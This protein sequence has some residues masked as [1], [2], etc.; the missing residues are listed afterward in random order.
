[1]V[2]LLILCSFVLI[3]VVFGAPT[4]HLQN[5]FYESAT[6]PSTPDK[7]AVA[8]DNRGSFNQIHRIP[9]K[10]HIVEP[11]WITVTMPPS[12]PGQ[13]GHSGQP[14]IMQPYYTYIPVPP[15]NQPWSGP[16]PTYHPPMPVLPPLPSNQLCNQPSNA[17]R[18]TY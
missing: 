17:Y 9:E 8:L 5:E 18:V 11:T 4:V 12:L 13:F 3:P 10:P 15:L 16:W 2:R 7:N 14:P 1:M 6:V